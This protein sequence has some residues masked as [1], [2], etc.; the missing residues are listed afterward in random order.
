MPN[1]QKTFRNIR[2]YLAGAFSLVLIST[3]TP[4]INNTNNNQKSGIETKVVQNNE[5]KK[6]YST[7]IKGKSVLTYEFSQKDMAIDFIAP[8][9]PATFGYYI[10]NAK[11][12]Y[13]RNLEFIT[14]GSFYNLA[15]GE[16]KPSRKKQNYLD[17]SLWYKDGQIGI[18]EKGKEK[19]KYLRGFP[20]LLKDGKNQTDILKINIDPYKT[21]ARSAIGVKKDGN[22]LLFFSDSN[23][24]GMQEIAKELKCVD[25]LY[26][27]SGNSRAFYAAGEIHKRDNPQRKLG[28]VIVGYRN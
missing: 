9:K 12:K 20:F 22:F 6:P 28:N 15:K 23:I 24:T 13:G 4:S 16:S 18:S 17:G 10:E 14:T 2:A 5:K 3:L 8:K 1:K 21:R 26:L 27:D 19:G 25:A 11:Q 7:E